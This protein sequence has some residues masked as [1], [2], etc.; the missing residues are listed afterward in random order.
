MNSRIP[1]TGA[2]V[3]KWAA[4]LPQQLLVRL[5]KSEAFSVINEEVL[6]E[7]GMYL[8][9]RCRSIIFV[10]DAVRGR[11]HCPVCSERGDSTIISRE[12]TKA[13]QE[14]RCQICG[15][16]CSWGE[17]KKTYHRKQLFEGAA[18]EFFRAFYRDYPNARTAR[19]KMI[20]ID[21]LIHEFH[22][23]IVKKSERPTRPTC[24]NLVQGKNMKEVIA[25]L[26]GISAMEDPSSQAIKK[27]WFGNIS[28]MSPA[29]MA[30]FD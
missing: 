17:Y 16:V 1:K 29:L 28:S 19:E 12:S 30:D 6:D 23:N 10:S 26:A 5:Y 3:V 2:T 13:E 20:K 15:W 9:L 7:V 18:K 22:Y 8:Y 4:K 11:I 24:A 25:F 27:Q 14:I 21:R